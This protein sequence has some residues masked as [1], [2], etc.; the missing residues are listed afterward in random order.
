MAFKMSRR[1]RIILIVTAVVAA[2]AL[3]YHFGLSNALSNLTDERDQLRQAQENYEKY[4]RDLR[5]EPE[6]NANFAKLEREYPMSDQRVKE[7]TAQIEETFK[8]FGIAQTPITVPEEEPIAGAEDYSLVTIRIQCDGDISQV[9]RILNFFD[10][11]AILIKE[12]SL[13]TGVDSNVIH[14]DTKVSQIVRVSEE[15][16]AQR[17]KRASASGIRGVKPRES[18]GL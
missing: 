2:V 10:R 3:I 14:V 13:R 17:T 5:R 15:M 9:A 1:E 16:K 12:L 4:I 11:Q 7:F 8:S 6:V 18:P